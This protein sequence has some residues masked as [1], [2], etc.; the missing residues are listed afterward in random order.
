MTDVDR[1]QRWN[2]ISDRLNA[3]LTPESLVLSE[4]MI[5]RWLRDH[6]SEY[7]SATE[8]VKACLGNFGLEK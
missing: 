5:S 1:V 8:A 4:S 6:R 7:N 2:R 3:E